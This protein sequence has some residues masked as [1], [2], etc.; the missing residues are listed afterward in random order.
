MATISHKGFIA[1]VVWKGIEGLFE[2]TMAVALNFIK[3]ET[4]RGTIVEYSLNHLTYD[5]DDWLATHLLA[6]AQHISLSQKIFTTI[7]LFA[8]GLL[9]IFMFVTL[10][11]KK[12]WAFPV[13]MVLLALFFI[14]QVIHLVQHFSIGFA[15]L[16]T[17]DPTLLVLVYIEFRRIYPGYTLTLKPRVHPGTSAV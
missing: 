4:L 17:V 14:Y 9:R 1:G 2:L 3:L 5:P 16:S 6:F 15:L 10:M 13:S 11:K 7:Y 12:K 8:H